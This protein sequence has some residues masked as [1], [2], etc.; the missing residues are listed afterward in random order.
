MELKVSPGACQ[1]TRSEDSNCRPVHVWTDD[2]GKHVWLQSED[3][4]EEKYKIHDEQS[5]S[6]SRIIEEVRPVASTPSIGERQGTGGSRVSERIMSS[7]MPRSHQRKDG[8]K[9]KQHAADEIH[10]I[11]GIPPGTPKGFN[12]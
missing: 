4:G 12:A 9:R 10:R 1:P 6:C 11:H 7:H 8:S 5:S 3:A 2:K